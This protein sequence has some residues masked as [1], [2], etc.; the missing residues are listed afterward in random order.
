MRIQHFQTELCSR[1]A[2]RLLVPDLRG[3]GLTETQDEGDLSTERQV[4]DILNIYKALFDENGDEEPPYVVVV[5]HRSV[6]F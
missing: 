6:C 4:K 5:G 2:C 1:I 3:H